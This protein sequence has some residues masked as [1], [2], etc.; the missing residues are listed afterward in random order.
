[1]RHSDPFVRGYAV[2]HPVGEVQLP[3]QPGWDQIIYAKSGLLV[4]RTDTESW[5][6]PPHRAIC[7]ADGVRIRLKTRRR[8]SVRCLYLRSQLGA[9]SSPI[10]V[11]SMSPFTRELL[12]HTVDACPLG[13]DSPVDAA[14]VTLLVD[15]I[16]AQPSAPLQLPLPVDDRA[17]QVAEIVL[18][19]PA[20]TIDAAA[21]GVGASRRTLERLFRSEAQMT[22]GGWQRR[23]RVLAA[24]E[25]MADNPS[26]TRTAALVGYATPSSFVAAFKSE[27]GVPPRVFMMASGD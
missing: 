17:R 3:T 18:A 19:D 20:I 2:T 21:S 14:L 26:V 12:L 10:R 23:A 25:L 9:G 11:V 24:I 22:L 13:S 4:A 27:L 16:A 15:Q 5:T 8:T 7:V 1:M 6:V